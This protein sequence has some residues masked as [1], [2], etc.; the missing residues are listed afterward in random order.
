VT[1]DVNQDRLDVI[2]AAYYREYVDEY[3]TKEKFA[4][5][6][7]ISQL[8]CDVLLFE[9]QKIHN[10]MVQDDLKLQERIADI[11]DTR[12]PSPE[13]RDDVFTDNM[14]YDAFFHGVTLDMRARSG[15][16]T[17]NK[18]TLWLPEPKKFVHVMA[19]TGPKDSKAELIGRQIIHDIQQGGILKVRM[20]KV[21][22]PDHNQNLNRT[23]WEAHILK[24]KQA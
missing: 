21:L 20:K 5:D 19:V 15:N 22:F 8:A 7:G 13:P 1:F 17:Y 16:H 4:H 9:G 6:H 24:K 18:Y 12:V 3:T 10:R 14:V 23:M 11:E 2:L